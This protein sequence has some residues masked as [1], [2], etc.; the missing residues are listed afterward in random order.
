MAASPHHRD[1]ENN[2]ENQNDGSESDVHEFTPSFLSCVFRVRRRLARQR[3]GS[4]SV[5]GA[6][7]LSREAKRGDEVCKAGP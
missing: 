5:S 1:E 4:V 7:N 3:L 2:D 6:T